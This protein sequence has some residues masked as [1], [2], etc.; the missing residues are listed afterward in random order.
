MPLSPLPLLLITTVYCTIRSSASGD[1]T[2]GAADDDCGAVV[3]ATNGSDTST[4][5]SSAPLPLTIVYDGDDAGA[6]TVT[7]PGTRRKCG[8]SDNASVRHQHVERVAAAAVRQMTHDHSC[9]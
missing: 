4:D 5:E 7:D 3:S 6:R 9:T 1:A 2:P 8:D